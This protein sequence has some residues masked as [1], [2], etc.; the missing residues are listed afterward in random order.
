MGYSM[1]KGTAVWYA[2][3]DS[4]G[5]SLDAHHQKGYIGSLMGA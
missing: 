3:G 1:S 2:P 4:P 5:P